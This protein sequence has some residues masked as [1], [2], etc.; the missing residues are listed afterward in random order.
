MNP[1]EFTKTYSYEL[2]QGGFKLLLNGELA[3]IQTI[4]TET[5]EAL[6][7]ENKEATAQAVVAAYQ[8]AVDAPQVPFVDPLS[9]NVPGV[10]TMRQARL[11]LLQSGLLDEVE[12]A[13]NAA[14]QA[15]RITW[16]FSSEVQRGNAFVATL[17]SALGLTNQQLD[18]LFIL[19]ATL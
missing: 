18:E 4:N 3:M 16:E 6:T 7:E 15:T 11:A 10:V 5:G 14:D 8:T 17:A 12:A 2:V 19:A 1:L 9:S 13:V